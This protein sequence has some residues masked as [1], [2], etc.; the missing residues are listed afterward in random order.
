M[1][2]IRGLFVDPRLRF[3]SS[4]LLWK[5]RTKSGSDAFVCISFDHQTRPDK[6]MALRFLLIQALAYHRILNEDEGSQKA[7]FQ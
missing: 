7:F 6:W 4:D 1:E 2:L 5:V 3:K